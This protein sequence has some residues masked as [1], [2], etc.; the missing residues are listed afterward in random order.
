MLFLD[1]WG[2]LGAMPFSLLDKLSVHKIL[3]I[4]WVMSYAG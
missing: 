4:I 2:T 3:E 1:N